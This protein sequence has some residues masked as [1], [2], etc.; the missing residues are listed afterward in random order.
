MNVQMSPQAQST[1]SDLKFNRCPSQPE[2]EL[3]NSGFGVGPFFL[4]FFTLGLGRGLTL[5][6]LLIKCSVRLSPYIYLT[7][8]P[9]NPT[10]LHDELPIMDLS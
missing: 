4:F 5:P 1:I 6:P 2:P 9:V 3:A 10:K 8:Q 7:Y